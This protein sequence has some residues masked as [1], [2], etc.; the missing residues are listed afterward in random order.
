MPHGTYQPQVRMAGKRRAG[1]EHLPKV[2][3]ADAWQ[4]GARPKVRMAVIRA[5]KVA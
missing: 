3:M 2:R 5:G 4:V 1:R